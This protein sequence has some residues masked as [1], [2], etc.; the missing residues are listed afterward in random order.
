MFNSRGWDDK[1]P[2]YLLE[3]LLHGHRIKGPCI[4]MNQTSTCV[5]E[6]NAT[7]LITE[8]GDIQI[9][10]VSVAGAAPIVGKGN[11]DASPRA[12]RSKVDNNEVDKDI[13]C[14][15]IAL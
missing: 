7:A 12:K 10:I 14:D 8:A 15:P 6:D 5:I 9:D 3:K 2:I 4:I 11:A 1:V 13:M